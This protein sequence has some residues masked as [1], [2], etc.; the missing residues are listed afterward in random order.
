MSMSTGG[1]RCSVRVLA[2]VG[3]TVAATAAVSAL[4]RFPQPLWY[5]DFADQRCFWCIPHTLN[6]LSNLPFVFIGVL[7]LLFLRRPEVRQPG[8]VFLEPAE[9]YPYLVL[10]IFVGL[11]GL[12]SA[13]YHWAPNNARLL[14]DR[15]PLAVAFMALL[16]AILGERL[17]PR[18]GTWLL[19]PLAALGAGSVIYWHVSEEHGAG[20]LRFYLLVQFFPLLCVPLLL[21]LFPARYTRSSDLVGALAGYIVAKVLEALDTQVYAQGQLVS[22]HTLKHLLGAVSCY[23]LLHMLRQRR[24]EGRGEGRGARGEGRGAKGEGRGTMK[25]AAGVACQSALG[26]RQ[27]A[28]GNPSRER[29]L[30]FPPCQ[31]YAATYPVDG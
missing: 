19:L 28:I 9:R 23:L 2:L 6:V 30:A 8:R 17:Q 29:P 13:Y 27:S 5:H 15:L 25:K 24:P 26:T 11:T 31:L 20:D 22:G 3:L 16:A 10:F 1:L 4:P 18:V 7:G 21:W 12:G 14:W